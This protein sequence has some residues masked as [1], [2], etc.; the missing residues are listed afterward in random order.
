MHSPGAEVTRTVTTPAT[1]RGSSSLRH[2]PLPYRLATAARRLGLPLLALAIAYL[3]LRRAAGGDLAIELISL[4][5]GSAAVVIVWR[6]WPE[7]LPLALYAHGLNLY[8]AVW[9]RADE[10]PFTTH[11]DYVLQLD[12]WLGF[13]RT[14]GERLQEWL[15]VPGEVAIHDLVLVAI[16]ASFFAAPHLFTILL[17]QTDRGRARR[18]IAAVLTMTALGVAVIVLVPTAPPWMAARQGLIDVPL[19]RVVFDVTR[20][21]TPGVYATGVGA[22]GINAVAAMPSIHMA[23]TVL[24]ALALAGRRRAIAALGAAYALTMGLA[25]VYLGEHYVTDVIAGGAVAVVGWRISAAILARIDHSGQELPA[26]AAISEVAGA[27][28]RRRAA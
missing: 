12:R 23:A 28:G 20:D 7:Q 19:Y 16:Y 17:W 4:V 25:L 22:A 5:G 13:G 8:Y 3:A 18:Y 11:F 24:I 2:A 21:V 9:H 1:R 26:P 14:P 6:R 10:T 27:S 15:Y